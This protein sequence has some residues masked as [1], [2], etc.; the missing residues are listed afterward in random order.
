MILYH[1]SDGHTHTHTHTK[2]KSHSLL[3]QSTLQYTLCAPYTH[4]Q[5]FNPYGMTVKPRDHF[6]VEVCLQCQLCLLVCV[7]LCVCAFSQATNYM[8]ISNLEWKFN[9]RLTFPKRTQAKRH[10]CLLP[11]FTV[12]PFTLMHTCP[13][14]HTPTHTL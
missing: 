13:R 10:R 4:I 12:L 8:N 11:L 3:Q 7:S 14:P 9:L 1:C 2:P 6:I 5:C